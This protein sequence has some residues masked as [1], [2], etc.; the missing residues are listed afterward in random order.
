MDKL[1]KVN[2]RTM[3]KNQIQR[4]VRKTDAETPYKISNFA[5]DTVSPKKVGF[6]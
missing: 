3:I 5:R 4:I 1:G 2:V 6:T